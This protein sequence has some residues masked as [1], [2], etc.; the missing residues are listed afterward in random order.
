M[1]NLCRILLTTIAFQM[2]VS[3]SY[4]E[5]ADAQGIRARVIKALPTVESVAALI[6]GD[7]TEGPRRAKV[8]KAPYQPT[9]R[10]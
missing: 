3:A 2:L 5:D 8:L 4:A 6:D 1:K 9:K 10:S 7:I